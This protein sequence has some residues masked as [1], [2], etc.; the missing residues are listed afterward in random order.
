[1]S[2]FERRDVGIWLAC[3]VRG[4]LVGF[5]G[6]L[7]IPSVHP[8]PQLVYALFEQFTGVGYAKEMARACVDEARRQQEFG[9]IVASVDELNGASVRVLEKVGFRKVA[10]CPGRFGSVIVMDL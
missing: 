5:C 3:D 4:D 8:E 1:M 7:E 6:F 9:T 2:L 10:T